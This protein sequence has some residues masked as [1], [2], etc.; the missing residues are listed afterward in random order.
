MTSASATQPVARSRGAAF[1]VASGI[2]LSRLAGLVRER[3]FAHYLGSSD[4]AGAFRAALRIP[5]LLQNLLGE[6]VLSAS[7]I[8]V[9]ARLLA[10]GE[11]AEAGRVAGV[12]LS[13]LM[14]VVS[15]LVALGVLG[16]R[17]LIDLIAP[18]FHGEVRELT[19]RLVQIMFPGVGLLVISAWCLGILN[20]HRRFFLSYVA[21]VLWNAAIIAT[22]VV[23]GWGGASARPWQMLLVERVAWGMVLGSGL[24]LLVQ[25]PTALRL[26]KPLRAG[27]EMASASMKR[28]WQSFV[29][30]V[31]SR[32]VVQVSAYIDE[33]LASFLGAHMMAAMAYAQTLY[34]LPISLFGM[35]VS[36]A[37]LPAMSGEL[38]TSGELAEKLK[39]RLESALGRIAF[40]VI[41]SVAA[42]VLLG[43]TVVSTLLQTGHFSRS[44]AFTVWLILLG[45][46]V[47]LLAVTWARLFSSTFY[48]LHDTRTPLRFAVL[49]V[50]LTALAGWACALPL[51]QHFGYSPQLASAGLTA[52]AG[53]AGWLEYWLLRRALSRRIGR[54]SVPGRRL[55]RLWL[56]ALGAA[57]PALALAGALSGSR[58]LLEGL[59]VLGLYGSLYLAWTAAWRDEEARVLLASAGRMLRR[60][61]LH[62]G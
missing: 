27:I 24:Q 15:L 22:L 4:A 32:G 52:S 13:L 51:R 54:F 42:F 21:P 40:F 50:V 19:I 10:R 55:R 56:A 29:P 12:V 16:A 43:E 35:S 11:A 18:G 44:D 33:L 47:G 5:N 60:F 26:A 8:P 58:P 62:R 28:V 17:L 6:G 36:A 61:I 49:R 34:L 37:E 45:S 48:A 7:F 57:A 20:S 3:V 14:L 25:L 31:V 1:A 38:A 9:Y 41:P 2:L 30:V 39:A 53:L 46:T 59:L 23:F